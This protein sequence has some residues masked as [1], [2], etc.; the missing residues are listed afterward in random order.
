MTKIFLG[1]QQVILQQMIEKG[2]KVDL[3]L[4]ENNSLSKYVQTTCEEHKIPYKYIKTMDD[5]LES[6]LQ[7]N[8]IDICIVGGFGVILKNDFIKKCSNIIN[9]HPADV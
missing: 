2:W 4:L 5:I 6:T 9:F 8:Q 7:Y 3:V 1:F